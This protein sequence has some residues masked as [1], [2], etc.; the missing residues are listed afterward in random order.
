MRN[1]IAS[2]MFLMALVGCGG[3]TSP[4]NGNAVGN[5]GDVIICSGKK[6][7]VLDVWEQ[8]SLNNGKIALG[9]P[10]SS[11]LD[12]ATYA[13]NR[14]SGIDEGRKHQY[15]K[16]IKSFESET[17]FLADAELTPIPDVLNVALPKDCEL[18]QL[19]IQ[20]KQVTEKDPK[21]VINKELW[22]QLDSDN[23]AA[24]VLH[25][26]I[27]REAIQYRNHTDSRMVRKFNGFVLSEDALK[28]YDS[29]KYAEL[30]KDLM[31]PYWANGVPVKPESILLN[32]GS[33]G[34]ADL[35]EAGAW[36]NVGSNRIHFGGN[37]KIEFFPSG[38]IRKGSRGWTEM[39]AKITVT[40]GQTSVPVL[41]GAFIEFY[42]NGAISAID[43]GPGAPYPVQ[44][45]QP[46]FYSTSEDDM[47]RF[48]QSGNLKEATLATAATLKSKDGTQKEYAAKVRLSFDE[49]GFVSGVVK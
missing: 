42:E 40:I 29:K 37:F 6:P 21:Y 26:I 12:K 38:S 28:G 47:T 25:E 48:Y 46:S 4:V 8:S 23:Q 14:L 9:E 33:I 22:D 34:S 31:L 49:D 39:G 32:K 11:Y 35:V 16:R 19:A 20:Q 43:L 18:K 24:L 15:L 5:G 27:Y 1:K 2:A 41:E 13:V 17:A 10:K 3:K 36:I 44:G 7:L 30:L 45:M